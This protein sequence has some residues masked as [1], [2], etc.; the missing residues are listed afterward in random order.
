MGLDIGWKYVGEWCTWVPS[1]V[2]QAVMLCAQIAVTA[3]ILWCNRLGDRAVMVVGRLSPTLPAMA[4][5]SAS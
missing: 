5:M 2:M 1:R 4:F 3:R